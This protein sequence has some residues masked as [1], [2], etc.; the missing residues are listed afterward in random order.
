MFTGLLPTSFYFKRCFIV[1]DFGSKLN[2]NKISKT[3][4][5]VF[6]V[7]IVNWI[8]CKRITYDCK[9]I[10]LYVSKRHVCDSYTMSTIVTF[11]P[12]AVNQHN[13]YLT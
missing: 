2:N 10:Y 13:R 7:K 12:I 8:Y 6:A 9:S 3:G 5:I 11:G 4:T 1:C